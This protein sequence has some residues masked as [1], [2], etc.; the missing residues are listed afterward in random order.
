M[1]Y[2]SLA[3]GSHTF[4]V[5]GTS[6]GTSTAPATAS[7][8]VNTTPPTTPTNVA[9]S[10]ASSALVNVSW[11]DSS[12]TT[13]VTG[14]TIYRNG[15]EVGTA[16]GTATTYADSTVAPSTPYTY[17][18]QATDGAGNSSALSTPPFP[19]TT[20]A[21]PVGP[22]LVQ[23]ASSSTTTV[24]LPKPTTAGDLLVLSAGLY[25]GASHPITAV[26]DGKNTWIKV[27]AYDVAGENS[28]GEMWYVPNAASVSSITV[29]TGAST[30]ALNVQEFSGVATASPLDVSAGKAATSTAASS[31]T[32]T[33]T[34]DYDLAVGFIAGHSSA[35]AIT[36]TSPGYTVEPQQNTT[37]P[38]TVSV[39]SGYQDLA[40]AGAQSFAGSFGTAM[41]WASG[42]ALFKS[43]A[44]PPPASDFSIGVAPNSA[45]VTAGGSTSPTVST[46]VTSGS[47]VTVALSAS[48]LPMGTTAGFTNQSITAGTS[49]GVTFAT[50]TT[51][52]A[53]QYPITITGTGPGGTPVH[54][55]TF[56]LTVQTPPA[57]TSAASATF[58]QGTAG[59]FEVTASGSPVPAIS[60]STSL[61]T[62]VTLVD[63]G[64]GTATLASTAASPTG[65]YTIN[66]T[67]NNGVGTVATQSFGLT[68]NPPA[69]N[70]S[71]G[72]APNSATVTAG[73][74][75]SPTVSTTVTSGSAVAVALTASGLPSG[76]TAGFTSQ[77]ITAGTS[78]G[79]TFN[80]SST[81]PAGQYPITI[82]GTGPGGTPVHTT[83]FTLTVQTPAGT[84]PHLVQTAGGTETT[85]ASSLTATFP[86]T[87]TAGDLLV[88]AASEDNGATNH[89]TSVTDSAGNTWTPIGAYDISGHDSNGELWYTADASPVTTVTV[90]NASTLSESFEVDDFTGVATSGPLDVSTGTS[91]TSTAA[92]SG[93]VTST[94][95]GELAVGFIAGH[96]SSQA[97]TITS[98]GFTAQAQQ[99]TITSNITT[100]VTGYQ[101]LGAPGAQSIAGTFGT[102]MYWAAGIAVFKPAS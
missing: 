94:V 19:V 9:A 23:S 26:S 31:G 21:A 40:A 99:N 76:T 73:G 55:T 72:V 89:I 63:N 61:P 6:G 50:S 65:F 75:T 43:G 17:Q 70:F 34:A 60:T 77:S 48:G 42:I 52:P 30:V 45:T 12:D 32:A 62:G 39:E 1:T 46:A 68:I 80:T 93:S 16:S 35:Q 5:I 87:T 59:S 100:V 24:T 11:T 97:I 102:A 7:W 98:T 58:N 28:D 95:A 36:V 27:G 20:P 83:T 3:N 86:T 8:T 2:N 85:S 82:T 13:G 101:V 18:V 47:A 88:L 10:A 33:A 53:G 90:H 41:Y 38:S 66:I 56:T 49:T 57:I 71:I 96:G 79:V 64:N 14:Y 22:V 51:T 37:S 67:A 29:T 25:T 81:T 74:S 84:T 44:P 92:N 15:S 78:T 91:N 69:S 54:T 4:S